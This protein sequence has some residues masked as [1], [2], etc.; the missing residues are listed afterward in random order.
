MQHKHIIQY[1]HQLKSIEFATTTLQITGSAFQSTIRLTDLE[2]SVREYII[3]LAISK[4]RVILHCP[5]SMI[6]SVHGSYLPHKVGFHTS[7]FHNYTCVSLYQTT[8]MCFRTSTH[9]KSTS[10]TFLSDVRALYGMLLTTARLAS[11]YACVSPSTGSDLK[12]LL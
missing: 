7:T 11:K 6:I 9:F 10:T 8:F 5:K 12:W 4:S 3:L 1:S 2:D